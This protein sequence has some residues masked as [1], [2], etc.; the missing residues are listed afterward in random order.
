MSI[1]ILA[2]VLNNEMLRFSHT[3]SD[4][5]YTLLLREIG[6]VLPEGWSTIEFDEAELT[7]PSDRIK[8]F[9]EQIPSIVSRFG[10]E[11]TKPWIHIMLKHDTKIRESV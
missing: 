10:E 6:G 1:H 7:E 9:F 8:E 2:V 3:Y 11:T 5:E 4:V